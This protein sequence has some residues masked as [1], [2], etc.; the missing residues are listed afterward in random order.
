MKKYEIEF[1]TRRHSNLSELSWTGYNKDVEYMGNNQKVIVRSSNLDELKESLDLIHNH[2]S[3]GMVD[4]RIIKVVDES[5]IF[6]VS[7]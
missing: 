6:P 3:Q 7:S 5:G 4:T 1:R 2:L